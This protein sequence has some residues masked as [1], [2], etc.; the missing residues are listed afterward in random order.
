MSSTS[1]LLLT[2]DL[3]DLPLLSADLEKMERFHHI[4]TVS[5]LEGHLNHH[6]STG[7]AHLYVHV[8]PSGIT[9]VEEWL[10]GP[11]SYS[12]KAHLNPPTI[13]LRDDPIGG[14]V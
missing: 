11:L 6:L 5:K 1:S 13:V 8:Y 14:R 9:V 2:V 4:E 7:T 10:N 12:I 3:M